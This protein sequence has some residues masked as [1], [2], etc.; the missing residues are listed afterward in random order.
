MGCYVGRGR[1]D[2]CFLNPSVYREQDT[3]Y[4]Y[5]HVD[6]VITYHSGQNEDWGYPYHGK[7][8]RIICKLS[9]FT[10]YNIIRILIVQ[11]QDFVTFGRM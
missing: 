3:Y 7:A 1:R 11:K 2:A 4:V 6:L 10:K 9:N 8:G 5:N